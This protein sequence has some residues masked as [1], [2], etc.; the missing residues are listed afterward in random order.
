MK[1]S[2]LL[3]CSMLALTAAISVVAC[4]DDDS[5][6]VTPTADGGTDGATTD[7]GSGA[8]ADAGD[9]STSLLG[10]KPSNLDN[11]P[12][13]EATLAEP[14]GDLVLDDCGPQ[15]DSSENGH[16]G[17]GGPP[18]ADSPYRQIDGS[19]GTLKYAVFVAKNIT[20]NAG[21]VLAVGGNR[22]LILIAK[23][24]IIINGSID[25]TPGTTGAYALNNGDSNGAGPGAGKGSDNTTGGSGGGGGFCG[26]GGKGGAVGATA[27][28]SYGDATLIPLQGGSAGGGLFAAQGG[29]A[30]QLV[31]GQEIVLAAGSYIDAHGD[32]AVKGGGAGGAVLLE[33]PSVK[34]LGSI[35]VNGGGGGAAGA[36]DGKPGDR[37]ATPAAGGKPGDG[38]N[39]GNG[40]A[41]ASP[42]GTDGVLNTINT[43]G[44]G[45]GSGGGGA[46]WIRINTRTG[47]AEISGLLSPTMGGKC[48]SQG[49]LR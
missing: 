21:R 27:G 9:G 29:G 6:P 22:P 16:V 1:Q 10:F 41:G 49:T 28:P 43:D 7:S 46:G 20:V 31:A 40:G 25:V 37:T 26:K 4:G 42:D 32:G 19:G 11:S 45:S 36:N 14:L 2:G 44:A 3:V 38:F 5:S 18:T 39:G 34:V 33:A 15:V 17:C 8:D 35:T 23:E 13:L 24:K 30:I 47:S 48:A 12:Q